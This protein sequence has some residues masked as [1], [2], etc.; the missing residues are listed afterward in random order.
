MQDVVVV[1][2]LKALSSSALLPLRLVSSKQQFWI[3]YPG[4]I[5]AIYFSSHT[6]LE[7]V[8]RPTVWS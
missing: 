2:S 8:V 1:V 6:I 4:S 7:F 5:L 3:Q